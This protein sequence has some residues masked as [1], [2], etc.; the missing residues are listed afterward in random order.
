MKKIITIYFSANDSS[1]NI[2]V[3]RKNAKR[4]AKLINA[5]VQEIIT[6]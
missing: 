1:V 4:L 2:R 3:Q 5:N 6:L